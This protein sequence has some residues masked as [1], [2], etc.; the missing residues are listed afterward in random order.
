MIP[1]R[2]DLLKALVGG[3]LLF[4]PQRPAAVTTVNGVVFG[5]ETFSFHD[6]PRPATRSS[7]RPS[8]RTCRRL[9]SP[10]ARSCPATSSRLPV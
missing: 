10:S 9:A 3:P 4:A 5:V 7:S 6:L 2:R 8:S 1:S